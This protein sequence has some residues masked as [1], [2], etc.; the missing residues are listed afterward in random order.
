MVQCLHELSPVFICRSGDLVV[1]L[2][3]GG[4]GG[5]SAL[6]LS[7]ISAGTGSVLIQCRK[8]LFF[9]LF[10]SLVEAVFCSVYSLRYRYQFAFFK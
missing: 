9:L 1:H 6:I 5:I 3:Q 10:G 8:I 7:N 4:R 2:L